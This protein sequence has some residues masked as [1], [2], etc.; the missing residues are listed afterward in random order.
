M[1]FKL[2]Y[3]EDGTVKG[4]L[5]LKEEIFEARCRELESPREVPEAEKQ[6]A[7]VSKE[8]KDAKQEAETAPT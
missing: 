7:P 6:K 1:G 8:N 3:L 5:D 4:I 2:E